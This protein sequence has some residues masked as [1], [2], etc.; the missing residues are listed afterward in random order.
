MWV[1]IRSVAYLLFRLHLNPP[2]DVTVLILEQKMTGLDTLMETTCCEEEDLAELVTRAQVGDEGAFER[3]YRAHVGRVYGISLRMLSNESRAEELTQQI[4]VR[5]WTKLSSFRGES[6]FSSWL[7]RLA[8]N[9]ILSELKSGRN[10]AGKA[11][12][13]G[14]SSKSLEP[15]A[16]PCSDAGIDLEKA[17]GSLPPQARIVFVMHDIEGYKHEEIADALG[18]AVGTAKS[19]LFRARRLLREALKS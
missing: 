18:V 2:G 10:N 3:I 7:Y 5:V 6:S 11:P 15:S 12:G 17:I 14:G 19:Q 1:A 16:A 8:V 9:M 13:M 4:F